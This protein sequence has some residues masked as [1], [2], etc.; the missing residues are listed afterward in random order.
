MARLKHKVGSAF[1]SQFVLRIGKLV[2]GLFIAAIGIILTIR[3]EVGYSP[4]D[5]LHVGLANT[6]G[7]SLGT[8]AVV[9]G[10][11]VVL[12]ATMLGETLGIGTLL[13]MLLIGVFMDVIIWSGFIPQASSGIMSAGMLAIGMV[14]LAIGM[15]F[16]ISSGFG[17]GPRDSLMVAVHRKTNLPIGICRGG[18]ELVATIIGY[19]LGGL[20]GIGTIITAVLIGP[21]VQVVFRLVHFDPRAIVHE[22]LSE[23]IKRVKH[24]RPVNT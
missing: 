22:R 13:N 21:I 15:Y 19:G 18:I 3:A 11:C 12:L 17:A 20:V 24:P 6:V 8:V 14:I 2:I 7:L 4:W 16:Y 23:T 5:V 10:A 1:M 9:V